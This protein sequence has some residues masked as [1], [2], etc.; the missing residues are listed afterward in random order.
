[1]AV[2]HCLSSHAIQCPTLDFIQLLGYVFIALCSLQLC[3]RRFHIA[4]LCLLMVS[5]CS[6]KIWLIRVKAK[7]FCTALLCLL[8]LY[9]FMWNRHDSLQ[10]YI[11]LRLYSLLFLLTCYDSSRSHVFFWLCSLLFLPTCVVLAI[12]KRKEFVL[13]I[14]LPSITSSILKMIGQ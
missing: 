10:S 13:V 9:S 2:L 6:K 8:I 12:S 4:L 11:P 5:G 7:S 14:V 3:V 1:M